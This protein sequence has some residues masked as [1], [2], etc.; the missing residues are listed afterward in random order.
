MGT[1]NNPDVDNNDEYNHSSTNDVVVDEE[2][3]QDTTSAGKLLKIHYTFGHMS[4][5]KLQVMAKMGI[6]P[7]QL[8]KI[9]PPTSSASLY[10]KIIKKA[11]RSKSPENDLTPPKPTEPGHTVSVD[12]LVSPTPGLIAQ[13]TGKLT[14]K[15][16]KNATIFVDNYPKLGY[17]YLQKTSSA[18]ETLKAKQAFE[19][20]AYSKGVTI[21][22]YHTDNGI[23]RAN[24]W[25]D[26]C[27]INIKHSPFRE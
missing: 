21:R 19:T 1:G 25:V 16:Y 20:Y 3:R 18:D 9:D 8:A 12:Q 17:V 27:K 14:V 6:I 10:S 23:F 11:W 24:K 5:A 13:L 2:D 7:K 15:R 26:A 4:F 22:V